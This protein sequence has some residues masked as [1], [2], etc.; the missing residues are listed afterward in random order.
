MDITRVETPIVGTNEEMLLSFIDFHRATLVQKCSGLTTEQARQRSVPPSSMSLLGL[1]R[2]MTDVEK[3]WF[4]ARFQGEE[5]TGL[6][7]TPED[8]DAAFNDLGG[9]GLE[10]CLELFLVACER[11]REIVAETKSLDQIA[12]GPRRGDQYVS[13]RWILFHLI[14]EYARHNGHADLLREVIDGSTGI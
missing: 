8:P 11:S 2:H 7:R 14:E 5:P 3:M 12:I 10:E 6:F 4:I 9:P 13:M 1:V